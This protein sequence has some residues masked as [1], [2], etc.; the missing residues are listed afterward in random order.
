MLAQV[1]LDTVHVVTEETRHFEPVMA[2]LRAGVD[3]RVEK[4]LSPD[5]DEAQM[6]VA[7]QRLGRRLM[8][9][10]LLRFDTRCAAVKERIQRGELGRLAT[11]YGR[12]NGIKPSCRST[13][14]PTASTPPASTTST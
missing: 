9:G 8:G 1:E 11:V 10:H 3:V 5:F 13:P 12:R 6:V 2:A 4:P 7:A 14:T